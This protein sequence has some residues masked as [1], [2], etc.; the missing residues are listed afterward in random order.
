MQV[1]LLFSACADLLSGLFP[2]PP[3]RA[4]LQAGSVRKLL[5]LAAGAKVSPEEVWPKVYSLHR[6]VHFV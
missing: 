3:A 2:A 4:E 1:Q 5:Q 6:K